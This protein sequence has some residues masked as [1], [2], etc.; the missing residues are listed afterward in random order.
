MKSKKDKPKTVRKVTEASPDAKS[1]L[2]KGGSTENQKPL[3]VE[4]KGLLY[5]K[6]EPDKVYDAAEETKLVVPEEKPAEQIGHGGHA[7]IIDQRFEQY[8]AGQRKLAFE[9]GE[10]KTAIKN[11]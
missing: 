3:F 5:N 4:Q 1:I 10:Q 11:L 2:K 9:L 6:I 7:H 8:L